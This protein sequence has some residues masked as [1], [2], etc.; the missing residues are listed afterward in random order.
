MILIFSIAIGAD[1]SFEV[2][3]IE[4]WASAFFKDNIS[5]VATVK[6]VKSNVEDA[7]GAY[8]VPKL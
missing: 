6:L 4:T 2:I 8:H 5:F 3:N 1:Y 7:G